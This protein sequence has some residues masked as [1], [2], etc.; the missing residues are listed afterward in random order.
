MERDPHVLPILGVLATPSVSADEVVA[1]CRR[2]LFDVALTSAVVPFD[3]TDY[4]RSE[5]GP[6]LKRFWCAAAATVGADLLADMKT[7]S[8]RLEGRWRD[9]GKRR[10]NLDP[11]YVTPLQLV[12]A[13]TKTLPQAV[14]LRDGI[15]AV[16][17][18]LYRDGV[19][20]PMPWTYPDYGRAASAATFEPFRDYLLGLL[21]EAKK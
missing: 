21:R 9:E 16:V 5:M 18:L 4:Y 7:A 6:D 20:A 10:V 2:E 3:D 19:F 14:Y 17:E 12:L 1:A 15:S 13:T 11:G 8:G